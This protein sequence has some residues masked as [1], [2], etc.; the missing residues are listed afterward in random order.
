MGL[1]IKKCHEFTALDF[2]NSQG[3]QLSHGGSKMLGIMEL[4]FIIKKNIS[5]E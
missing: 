2:S 1:K 4:N 5:E 3:S